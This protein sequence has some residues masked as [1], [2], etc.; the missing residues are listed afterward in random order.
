MKS[1]GNMSDT[2]S[3]IAPSKLVLVISSLEVGG[4]QRVMT[5]LANA[6]SQRFKKVLIITLDPTDEVFFPLDPKVRVIPA[7]PV[8]RGRLGPCRDT[9]V[10]EKWMREAVKGIQR[11]RVLRRLLSQYPTDVIVS[12][13]EEINVITLLASRGRSTPVIVSD[14]LDP[15]IRRWLSPGKERVRPYGVLRRITYPWAG[16]VVVQTE[17]AKAGFSK[18]L[19]RRVFVI[20]NAVRLSPTSVQSFDQR[21]A[22]IPTVVTVGRVAKQKNQAL[23]LRAF[24]RL[25]PKHPRWRLMIVGDGPL[26]AD[27]EQLVNELG[28]ADRTAITGFQKEPQRYLQQADLFVLT[29]H[30]EGF[31]NALLEAM[32]LGLPVISTN[33]DFGPAEII[34]DG[35]NGILVPCLDEDSLVQ[36]MDRLMSDPALRKKLGDA[37][38]NVRSRYSFDSV[39]F[40]WDEVFARVF[41]ERRAVLGARAMSVPRP[42]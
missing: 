17:A 25:L 10:G 32:S 23:L 20:P 18:R 3:S 9:E 29:S 7:F 27:L 24:A 38:L 6:W 40:L 8:K 39:L 36:A 5:T 22:R 14:R 16:A 11:V 34:H 33:C 31:P 15:N 35:K 41:S 13:M 30:A 2:F 1:L 26:R 4:A 42:T 12:F 37:A 19:Q 21:T 28:I